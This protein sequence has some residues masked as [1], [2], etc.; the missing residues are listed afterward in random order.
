MS[1][2]GSRVVSM[3]SSVRPSR[4]AIP[5]MKWVSNAEATAPRAPCKL[6]QPWWG[7]GTI[8]RPAS[9]RSTAGLDRARLRARFDGMERDSGAVIDDVVAVLAELNGCPGQ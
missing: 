6:V 2:D 3:E 1:G 9:A 7:P 8:P 5:I 4:R